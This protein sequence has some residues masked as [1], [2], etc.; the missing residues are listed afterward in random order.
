MRKLVTIRTVGEVNPIVDADNIVSA[1]VDGW[2]VVVKKDEFKVG[3]QAVFFEIDSFLPISDERYSFLASKATTWEGK[4]GVRLRTIRLRK[5]LS[6][7]LLLPLSLFPEILNPT[8]NEDIS[9]L[10][11]VEK[12]ERPIPTQLQGAAKGNFPY[13]IRKTDQERAQNLSRELFDNKHKGYHGH[14]NFEITLKLDGTSFTGYYFNGSLGVCSRNLELKL[15]NENNAYVR[16]FFASG[17][18]KALEK[19]NANIAIQGELCGEGIQGNREGLVGTELFVFDV[20]LIDEQRYAKP[21]ERLV[22]LKKLNE[23][24]FDALHVPFVEQFIGLP[25]NN[26]VDL[27]AHADGESLSNK[28]RE[29]LVYKSYDSDFTFKT[30]SN[31]FLLG[32][33]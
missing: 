23:F 21:H 22:V 32:E 29:G 27:L 6:Q 16:K 15:D 3:D 20:W 19:L 18:D 14:E 1:M 5:T 4:E 33:K 25:A 30:I 7:G 9:E 8:E 28:V 24:G 10:L 13:F 26:M 31:K 11:G 12:W 2:Q 17:L